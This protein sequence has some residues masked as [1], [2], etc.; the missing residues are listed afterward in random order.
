M[1]AKHAV[2]AKGLVTALDPHHKLSSVIDT[3]DNRRRSGRDGCALRCPPSAGR[4]PVAAAYMTPT[5]VLS[6]AFEARSSYLRGRV[7]LQDLARTLALLGWRFD[8]AT[9]PQDQVGQLIQG[10]VRAAVA[11]PE[12][13]ES[14][15]GLFLREV[16]RA[17]TR[18]VDLAAVV[19]G[20][21][22]R[23]PLLAGPAGPRCVLRPRRGRA[24]ASPHRKRSMHRLWSR[25]PARCAR[26]ARPAQAS[27][28][29]P[30]GGLAVDPDGG[31][32][33]VA[34]TRLPQ[35]MGT[36]GPR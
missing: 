7:S 15:N 29:G 4:R 5:E 19:R 31:E 24:G 1:H 35:M 12:A 25:G 36:C 27:R 13:A 17:R 34:E 11:E 26:P 20:R 9:H 18:G 6:Y 8:S 14:F 2:V 21:A 3:G 32:R 33:L 16:V 23:D 10:I 22:G 30:G 28:S